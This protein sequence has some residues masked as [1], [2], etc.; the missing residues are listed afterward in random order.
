MVFDTNEEDFSEETNDREFIEITVRDT[1]QGISQR[2][3][4]KIFNR[5]FQANEK[6]VQTGTGIGLAFVKELVKLHKGKIFVE[7]K[8]G[9]GS[10]FTVRIPSESEVAE[11]HKAS[12]AGE[13]QAEKLTNPVPSDE[14]DADG[15]QYRI[16]LVVED[17][18]DVRTLIRSHFASKYRVFEANDGKEGWELALETIPDVIVSD[19]LMPDVDGYEFCRKLKKDERTSH[20]PVLLLTALHSKEHE[21]KGLSSGADDYITKPFD[22]AILQTK[23]DNMLSIRD[24]LKEKY[25][26]EVTL[27]PK[28]ILISSPEEKFL[29]KA[30]EVVERN[31]EDADLDIESFARE[32]GVSRMQLYRKLHALTD[33]TVKEFIRSIRLKRA[34]QLLVQE[35]MSVSEIAYAVG[36]KDLSHFRKCFR[37]MYGMTATEYKQKKLG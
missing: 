14:Q 5:F 21:M 15:M 12:L 32:V 29:H 36:F 24:S 22:L 23:I 13:S 10:K 7:S 17:N 33:M 9:K 2:N 20:I 3:T 11:E 31:I 4:A 27:Q 18:P 19:I 8:P 34:A 16:M 35:S 37:Q 6:D 28:N 26:G 1:G 25:S 30:V